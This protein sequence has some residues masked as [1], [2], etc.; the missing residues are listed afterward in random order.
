M[1]TETAPTPPAPAGGL[2]GLGRGLRHDRPAAALPAPP[3]DLPQL[4]RIEAK[5]DAALAQLAQV[6]ADI[7]ATRTAIAGA[8]QDMPKF[9][10]PLGRMFGVQ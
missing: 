4:D 10:G 7:E 8:V 2:V 5:V 6:A 1:N 3:P 9:L